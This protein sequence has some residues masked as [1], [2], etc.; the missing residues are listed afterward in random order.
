[1]EKKPNVSL[2]RT[3]GPG[4]GCPLDLKRCLIASASLTTEQFVLNV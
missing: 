4:D 2:Q 1:M 3:E